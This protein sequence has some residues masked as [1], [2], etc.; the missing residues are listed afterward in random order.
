[1]RV[2][3]DVDYCIAP[4]HEEWLRRY[5]RDYDDNLTHFQ[6]TEWNMSN[7]VKPECGENIYKY[8]NDPD[9]YDDMNP[10]HGSKEA[11][12]LLC[13]YGYDVRFVTSGVH[14]GKID[15]LYR[16]KFIDSESDYVIAADKSLIIGDVLVDDYGMNLKTFKGVG[17][18]FDAPHNRSSS[19]GI[20]VYNWEEVV[21]TILVTEARIKSRPYG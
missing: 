17:I 5:N 12:A 3:L 19:Y 15:F 10:V 6:I 7:F 13:A 4:L 20:R 1:M 2:L 21:N 9:L 11:V 14:K 18:L 16:H 8:L